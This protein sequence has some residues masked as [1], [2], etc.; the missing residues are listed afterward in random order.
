[1]A[2]YTAEKAVVQ[3]PTV[4]SPCP[5]RGIST[6]CRPLERLKALSCHEQEHCGNQICF[7]RAAAGKAFTTVFAGFAATFTSLPK[8]LRMPAFV[9]GFTRVLMRQSPGIVKMPFFFTSPVA[10]ETKV[11]R[12]SEHCFCFSSNSSARA[13]VIAPL[14]IALELLFMLAAFM[15][16]IAFMTFF[17]ILLRREEEKSRNKSITTNTN[18][19]LLPFMLAA[20]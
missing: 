3:E 4:H 9:A 19:C 11:S 14:V 13:F 6:R 15:A 18:H 5:I 12:I 2:M 7:L 10:M 8:M 16:F 20:F 1:M 17:A